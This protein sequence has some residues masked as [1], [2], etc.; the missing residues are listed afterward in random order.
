MGAYLEAHIEQ[1][2]QLVEA[3]QPVAICLA[4]PGN[5]RH[6]FIRITGEEAHTGLPHRFRRD[7]ALA[8]AE[9]S[10]ALERLWLE[11]EALGRPMAVTIGRFH[12]PADRH[13]LTSVSGSFEMSLDLRAYSADHLKSLEARL[14]RIAV[15][16]AER[17]HVRIELGERSAAAPGP[18]H[19]VI[20]KGLTEAAG[21]AG[22][23]AP[24][25]NSPGSHDANNF[26]AAGVPTG[27]LLV[28]NRNGSHNPYEAMATPDLMAAVGVLAE[29]LRTNACE[30]S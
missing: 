16:V 14:N 17:R 19:P 22:L 4:N 25:L 24:K 28:R 8:G 20:V 6:P 23:A 10:L 27:M 9:F 3:G 5:V 2:P 29:W 7:A 1:A 21:R 15:D 26:A 11:E 18:M 30:P 12:T 13:S